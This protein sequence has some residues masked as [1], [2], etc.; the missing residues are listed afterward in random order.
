MLKLIANRDVG[1][2]Y[3]GERT[4][5]HVWTSDS[6]RRPMTSR[7]RL[8]LQALIDGHHVEPVHAVGSFGRGYYERRGGAVGKPTEPHT[9]E[10]A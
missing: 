8:A 4:L 5:R 7:E 1:F 2:R 10:D 9:K 6:E 3:R